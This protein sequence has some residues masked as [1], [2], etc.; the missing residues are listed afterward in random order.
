MDSDEQNKDASSKATAR[1][2]SRDV[3]LHVLQMVLPADWT[4]VTPKFWTKDRDSLETYE[5]NV[6][7]YTLQIELKSDQLW[8]GRLKSADEVVAETDRHKRQPAAIRELVELLEQ[9]TS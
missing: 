8:V 5:A 1:M 6:D 7:G 4:R 9:H 3:H 2:E